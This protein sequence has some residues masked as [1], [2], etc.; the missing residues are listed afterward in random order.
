MIAA[1]LLMFTAAACG[2]L[3][4]AGV[5]ALFWFAYT[6]LLWRLGWRVFA[7]RYGTDFEPAQQFTAR[8]ATFGHVF[9][10]YKGT[11]RVAFLPQ[12]LRFEAALPLGVAHAPFLLPWAC[13]TRAE[14]QRG[15]YGERA[16]VEL[17]DEAGR[18]SLLLPAPALTA[19]EAQRGMA[20]QSGT[21]A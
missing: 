1:L 4:L 15:P 14:L 10:T 11:A 18:V 16:W 8:S 19:L 12:G 2:L 3:L 21:A 13:V 17:R 6:Y 9:A 20:A 7:A 5:L